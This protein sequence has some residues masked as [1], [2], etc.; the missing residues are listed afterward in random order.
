MTRSTLAA[1]AACVG[2]IA[3]AAGFFG[4]RVL[5]GTRTAELQVSD[6]LAYYYPMMRWGF[7]QIRSGH[8][9]LWNPYQACGTPFLAAAHFG[10]FYPPYVTFLLLP[11]EWA[12]N[13]DIVLHLTIAA[14][15]MCWLCRHFGM[16]WPPSFLAGIVYAYH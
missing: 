5:P 11:A 4:L 15:T 1:I 6:L 12:I 16:G 3:I 13:V 9:P 14:L 8:V 10:F 7:G 2:Y